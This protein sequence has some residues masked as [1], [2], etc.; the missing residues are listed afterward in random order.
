M[1]V[2]HSS[3]CVTKN[4]LYEYGK[5]LTLMQNTNGKLIKYSLLT[6]QLKGQFYNFHNLNGT[7]TTHYFLQF[8]PLLFFK[9]VI[10]TWRAKLKLIGFFVLDLKEKNTRLSQ[11]KIFL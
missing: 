6:F 3:L 10:E 9:Y 5:L 7:N 11:K 2:G 4:L 1:A 8:S